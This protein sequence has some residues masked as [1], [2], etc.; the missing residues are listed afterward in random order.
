MG[1][2]TMSILVP[3]IIQIDLFHILIKRYCHYCCCLK[4]AG[5]EK[6][7][8]RYFLILKHEFGIPSAYMSDQGRIWVLLVYSKQYKTTKKVVIQ[9]KT[10]FQLSQLSYKDSFYS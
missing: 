2:V 8:G 1:W 6:I 5:H 10:Q 9:E 4:G 7:D 3:F